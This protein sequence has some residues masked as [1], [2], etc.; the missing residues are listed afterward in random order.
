MFIPNSLGIPRLGMVIAKRFIK[1]AVKRNRLKRLIRDAFRRMKAEIGAFDLV[2]LINKTD[3]VKKEEAWTDHVLQ[4]MVS[5]V[6][7][8][9]VTKCASASSATNG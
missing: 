5:T 4:A 2:V 3:L 1:A 9:T 7:A 6:R 8:V